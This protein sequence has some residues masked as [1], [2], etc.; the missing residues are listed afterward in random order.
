MLK[1]R[2]WMVAVLLIVTFCA[3][4][5]EFSVCGD[6]HGA[7]CE[8]ACPCQCHAGPTMAFDNP[9]NVPISPIVQ[10]TVVFHPQWLEV[11]LLDDVFRPPI[12]A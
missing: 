5:E 8:T 6:S 1:I 4:M 7:D 2:A 3:A 9:A 11:L 10:F 12:A